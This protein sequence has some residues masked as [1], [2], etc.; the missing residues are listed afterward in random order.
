MISTSS[1]GAKD[2]LRLHFSLPRNAWILT[3]TSAVWSIG[4]AAANPYQTLYFAALGASALEI[5]FYVA[6]GTAVTVLALL[7]G[8]YV[9]DTWGRRN[10][11]IVFSWVSVAAA[12]IYAVIDSSFLIAIPLTLGSVASVYTP[13]FNSVM[14]DSIEPRDRIRGFSVFNAI[15]TIPSVFSPTIGG[16]LMASFG[17][18]NGIRFAYVASTVFGVVG[19]SLRMLKLGESYGGKPA[20]RKSILYYIKSSFTD[21][22]RATR[23]SSGAVK[24]LLL[25]VSLAGVGTGL[26][27]PYVS[28]YVV[29]Y[30]RINPIQYSIVVDLAGLTTVILLLGIIFLIQRLG[31]RRS[32]MVA[33]VASPLSNVMFTQAKTMDE[34]LEW[35][36][37]G[38]VATALQTPSLA[39]VQAEAIPPEDRG[40]LLAMFSILPAIVSLPSQ[41]LAGLLYTSISPVAPFILSLFPFGVGALTLYSM[42][43]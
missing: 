32:V 41:M 27:A 22:M 30:L 18:L 25:Y 7:V 23:S 34:L 12:M 2:R 37:T 11:I 9:A 20:D 17:I 43:E 31:A 14:M 21:G 1:R 24:K 3:S 36:V 5:G 39:T 10:V 29:D 28:I 33:S 38:A 6:Y 26:T 16:V 15:N 4:A 8:G 13:A 19:V 42:R 35:G 40:K